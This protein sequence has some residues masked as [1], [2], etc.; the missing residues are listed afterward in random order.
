MKKVQ[1]DVVMNR[2][3]S[4][5]WWNGGRK[6]LEFKGTYQDYFKRQGFKFTLR[7]GIFT[8]ETST[9]STRTLHT[10]RVCDTWS[11]C[12]AINEAILMFLAVMGDKAML[13]ASGRTY[14]V[15]WR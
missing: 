13:E 8:T 12:I 2:V 11:L 5:Y 15:N 4:I 7:R 6:T 10:Q 1:I 9:S 3:I 14:R